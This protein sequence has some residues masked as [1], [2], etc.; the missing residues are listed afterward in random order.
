MSVISTHLNPPARLLVGALCQCGVRPRGVER[1]LDSGETELRCA[2]CRLGH[3][4]RLAFTEDAAFGL[5]D[6][7]PARCM[8]FASFAPL[9][10]NP[11]SRKGAK[12]A[13]GISPVL[14][15][16]GEDYGR[17]PLWLGDQGGQFHD[18]A[19]AGEWEGGDHL[20]SCCS[21]RRTSVVTSL[22]RAGHSVR[23]SLASVS[24]AASQRFSCN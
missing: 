5:R 17:R 6:G 2:P 15:E 23:F 21:S 11:G 20:G 7:P 9:R 10:E 4:C 1:P 18:D 22:K 3:P 14:T 24:V 19:D 12:P 8:P 13:K 16:D